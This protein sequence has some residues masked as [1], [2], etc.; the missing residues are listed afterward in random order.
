MMIRTTSP[1]SAP[2]AVPPPRALPQLRPMRPDD[3]PQIRQLE[4]SHGLLTL[5]PEDW[6][7]IILDNPLRRRLGD[8]WPIGWVL[9]DDQRRI[10]GSMASVVSLYHRRGRE[11]IAVT[12]RG[13]VV[14]PKYRGVALWLMDEYFNQPGADLFI[15]TTVNALAVDAF[16]A[17]GSTRVPLGDWENAAFF[18]TNYRGFASAA[19]RIKRAPAPGLLAFPAGAALWTKDAFTAPKLAA[20]DGRVDVGSTSSFDSRFDDFWR[21]LLRKNPDKLLAARD[22]QT[23]AWHFYGP[24][25]SGRAWI[26][27]ASQGGLL[28]AYCILKRQDHPQSGLVRMRLVDYQTLEPERDL[29]VDLLCAARR[30]GTAERIHVLEHVGCRLQKMKSF[31]RLAPYRRKLLA[32]PFYFS[33]ADPALNTELR[34]P[35][36]WDPSAFDG[37]A[38]L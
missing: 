5:S 29:L 33:A 36:A 38:S 30:R 4:S 26:L 12:G 23:L 14:V 32:W 6:R 1:V 28:R 3:Y 10:V 15:N 34:N 18:I 31:D 35:Q 19:L 16:S 13:W 21:E 2:T 9:E 27:T 11:L 8:N 20:R 24:L 25:R 7:G 37:D 17:F 22:T